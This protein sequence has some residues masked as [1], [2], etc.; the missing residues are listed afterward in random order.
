MRTKPGLGPKPGFGAKTLVAVNPVRS[1]QLGHTGDWDGISTVG[2]RF[3][4][5]F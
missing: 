4:R 5:W 3:D 2:E 1:F